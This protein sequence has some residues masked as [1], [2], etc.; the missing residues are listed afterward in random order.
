MPASSSRPPA[1]PTAPS[2]ALAAAGLPAAKVNPCQARRFAEAVGRL[3]K[4][5]RCDAALLAR[6]GALI[7]PT[8]RPVPSPTLDTMRELHTARSV[9]AKDRTVAFNRQKAIRSPLLRRQNAQTLR[10]IAAQLDAIDAELVALCAA[11]PDLKERLAILTSIP[12]LRQISALALLGEIPELGS[13]GHPQA[14]SLAGLA[15]IARDSGQ[16]RG[17]RSIQGGRTGLRQALSMPALVAARFNPDLKAKYQTLIQAGKPPKLA[18]TAVMRK[19]LL[20]AHALLRNR[21]AW[22]PK[23]A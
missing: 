2:S 9:L 11:D 1:P 14:A 15:P 20:L 6:F 13:L 21:R 3:A 5:D 23:L 17:R 19:L 18:I 22:S 16:F 10:Q 7:E 8:A 4:T 12:G